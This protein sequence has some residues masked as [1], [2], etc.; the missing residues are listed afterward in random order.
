MH[1][2]YEDLPYPLPHLPLPGEPITTVTIGDVILPLLGTVHCVLQ[3]FANA[4]QREELYNAHLGSTLGVLA[5]HVELAMTLLER[6]GE[7]GE[8]ED[9]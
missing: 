2:P 7:G 9:T 1:N 5:G 4:A 6:L 3:T 8:D